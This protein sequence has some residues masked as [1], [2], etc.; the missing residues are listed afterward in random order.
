LLCSLLF[1][2]VRI[3]FLQLAC[4]A[5]IVWGAAALPAFSQTRQVVLLHDE[6]TDLPGLSMLDAGFVR[7]LTSGSS[8]HIEV[9]REVMDLSRFGSAAYQL[10]L[11][12][13]L[14]AKY[15]GKK[16]DVAVAV[17]GPALEF[18]LR[19]GDAIF[20]GTPIVFCGIDG[21]MFGGRALPPHV[22]GVLLKREFIPTL[23]LVLSLHPDTERIVFVAGTSEFDTRLV[24]QAREKF[25]V[26]DDSQAENQF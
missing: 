24:E 15:A 13:H 23:E 7:T 16:I 2:K 5:L 17:M 21:R 9:Y 26:F 25:R 8:E 4:A 6:R 14:A 18:L 20:P 10:L 11:R 1:K 12:D 22:T 19:H 3:F